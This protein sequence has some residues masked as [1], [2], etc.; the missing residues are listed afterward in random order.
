MV[1]GVGERQERNICGS[2][3][4]VRGGRANSGAE[5][6][7]KTV[8]RMRSTRVGDD[9]V[10]SSRGGGTGEGGAGLSGTE[11]TDGG[12]QFITPSASCR[13]PVGPSEPMVASFTTARAASSTGCPPS[14][15]AVMSVA[16]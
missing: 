11:H 5:L 13:V 4:L 6:F 9:D 1:R 3:S 7:H 14:N 10:V 8:Q 2:S 15:A 16:V 12:H